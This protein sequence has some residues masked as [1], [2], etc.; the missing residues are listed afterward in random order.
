MKEVLQSRKS[1]SE[2][3]R[4]DGS[5]AI[6]LLAALWVRSEACLDESSCDPPQRNIQV[7]A[8]SETSIHSPRCKKNQTKTIGVNTK[9]APQSGDG[10]TPFPELLPDDQRDPRL[11]PVSDGQNEY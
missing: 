11:C 10:G 8:T 1:S 9:L 6:V 7:S 4:T 2:S 5:E 3:D